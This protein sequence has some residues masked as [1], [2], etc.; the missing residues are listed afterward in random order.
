MTIKTVNGDSLKKRRINW[1]WGNPAF[2]AWVIDVP[3]GLLVVRHNHEPVRSGRRRCEGWDIWMDG[4]YLGSI[5]S[6]SFGE[7]IGISSRELA[8][9]V[10]PSCCA[11]HQEYP[12][13]A[14]SEKPGK[15][16]GSRPNAGRKP[17]GEGKRVRLSVTVDPKTF[18]LLERVR[19]ENSRGQ[20]L[21]HLIQ[22]S[23]R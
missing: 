13:G 21:D 12:F 6:R 16:G 14:N 22:S 1:S 11:R 8:T 19:G 5:G 18:A 7:L 15:H 23:N 3:A 17:R 10:R 4:L 2:S 20:Y 9:M